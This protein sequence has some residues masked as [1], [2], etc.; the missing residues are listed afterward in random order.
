MR[1]KT[2]V[3]LGRQPRRL[4][5]GIDI[6]TAPDRALDSQRAR[7][8]K[9]GTPDD[10]PRR[11]SATRL[12]RLAGLARVERDR[13]RRAIGPYHRR[14]GHPARARRARGADYRT[15][16]VP[17]QPSGAGK[18]GPPRPLPPRRAA[19]V[20]RRARAALPVGQRRDGRDRRPR[21]DRGLIPS[22]RSKPILFAE[23]KPSWRSV[24]T[25]FED[26]KSTRL[27]SSH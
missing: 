2:W 27:N 13:G 10:F 3:S 18:L 7:G 25:P 23:V 12:R 5:Y 1:L 11:R 8:T 20:A 16:L 14:A 21:R 19:A 22:F 4:N 17:S 24:A 15:P 26:R 6:R 9:S